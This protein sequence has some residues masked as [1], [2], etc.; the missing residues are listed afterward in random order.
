[1]GF[2]DIRLR[3]LRRSAAIRRLVRETVLTP[4]DLIYP[5]FVVGGTDVRR[6]IEAMPGQYH[7][8]VDRLIAE[9]AAVQESG[10]SGVI[11]F[12]LSDRKDDQASGAYRSHGP[13]QQAV[14]ELRRQLPDL[15][16][17]TDVCLCGYMDHGHCGVVDQGEIIN[18]E[19]L[20]LLAR[21]A[22][23][24]AAAGAQ[25]VA[26]SDMMDGRVQAIRAAL[27]ESGHQ[28][29]AIMSYSAKYASAFYGPFRSAA[30]SAPSFGD[31]R[32]YQMD[33]ANVR[34][35]LREVEE[36][37]CEGADMVMIKPALAYLDVIRAVRERC[38]V[39]VA[40]YNV[41]GEYSMVKAAAARGW[42][43][44][45]AVVLEALTAMRRA[46]ADMILTYHAPDAAR[47]LKTDG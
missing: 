42:I 29:V 32:T 24:H 30:Q 20:A 21:A 45:R 40:A 44:E 27:D 18:D 31:R 33:P 34:E 11:L 4:A 2:P 46:G 17:A 28:Q 5:M 16:V 8:S 10:V 39:P 14:S 1:M 23:S 7:L 36:D 41:S 22:V 26:P 19:S 15:V 35:A 25:I 47:W 37:L 12:G 13:V 6:E 38:S 9:A 3:R 43:D